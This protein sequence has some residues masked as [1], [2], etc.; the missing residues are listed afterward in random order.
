MIGGRCM[1]NQKNILKIDLNAVL[2]TRKEIKMQ[3]R[4]DWLRQ[5]KSLLTA[6]DAAAVL[7]EHPYRNSLDV[8]MDKM[9]EELN[10]EDNDHL[11]FGRDVEG[12]IANLYETRTGR[13][14]I[15]QGSTV[16]TVHPSIPW[17]GA[18][19]DRIFL[20]HKEDKTIMGP[21][22]LKHVG[23]FTRKD[24]WVKDPPMWYQIQTQIQIACVNSRV[25]CLAG[26]FS[27]YQLG[28]KDFD[29]DDEFFN[30]IY[31]E[32]E[33]F[34]NHNVRKKIPPDVPEH[35]GALSSVKRLYPID[36]R[37]TMIL[38]HA[39]MELANR[40]E[41]VK[42]RLKT[43][44]E[45]EAELESK[46]RM[47]IGEATFGALPDGS[48]LSLKTIKNNGYTKKVEPFSYR[49]LGRKKPKIRK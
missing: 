19:L 45:E 6:S 13:C 42:I 29:R 11:K 17:L 27:G 41:E 43:V 14:V 7:N 1:D 16:I 9:S 33:Y 26:M 47:L 32:L 30:L 24:E 23:G 20:D 25:G 15:D 48:F 4:E 46:L 22:E 18:T 35:Q 39:A 5:R 38:D 12:A 36:N 37:E 34:W 31:P 44:N 40:L 10:Q 8:F 2:A 49:I 3:S 21:L 28:W